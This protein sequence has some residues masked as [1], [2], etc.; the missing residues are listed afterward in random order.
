LEFVSVSRGLTF[1][2]TTEEDKRCKKKVHAME[3][4]VDCMSGM[5]HWLAFMSKIYPEEDFIT[6]MKSTL[7]DL[8]SFYSTLSH[9]LS[10]IVPVI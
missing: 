8:V 4:E 7:H 2:T 6:E 9:I 3:N 1:E 10:Q 5:Q